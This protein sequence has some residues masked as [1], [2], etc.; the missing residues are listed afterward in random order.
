[1]MALTSNVNFRYKHIFNN[2]NIYFATIWWLLKMLKYKKYIYIYCANDKN[3]CTY[4]VY[5]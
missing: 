4:D 5:H 2:N 1:M 3:V